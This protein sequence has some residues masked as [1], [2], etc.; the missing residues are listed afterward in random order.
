V[1]TLFSL[2]VFFILAQF[3]SRAALEAELVALWHQVFVLRR[4]RRRCPRLS[5]VDR[6]IWIWLYRLSPA[7]LDALVI[8]KTGDGCAIAIQGRG[9]IVSI[10]MLGGLH[11]RYTRI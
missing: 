8:V 7:C 5:V 3:R 2:L 10:P 1:R 9:R 4:R 6:L 11:H